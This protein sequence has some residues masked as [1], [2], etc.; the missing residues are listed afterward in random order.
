M[1]IKKYRR[2]L[3]YSNSFD[4][5]IKEFLLQDQRYKHYRLDVTVD[6]RNMEV[7]IEFLKEIGRLEDL[8]FERIRCKGRNSKGISQIYN[9]IVEY[10]HSEV[11]LKE[12]GEL[13]EIQ[14][15]NHQLK[16]NFLEVNYQ[17]E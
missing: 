13:T 16:C 17:S 8:W 7:F 4:C 9:F 11:G 3:K 12:G 14:V 1:V 15:R 2:L 10:M 6:S 5:T